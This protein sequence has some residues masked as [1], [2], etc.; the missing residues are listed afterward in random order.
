M[1]LRPG[2]HGRL[3]QIGAVEATLDGGRTLLPETIPAGDPATNRGECGI[4]TIGCLS[5]S[6]QPP[7]SPRL[8]E[9]LMVLLFVVDLKRENNRTL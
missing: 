2:R 7:S 1:A 4:L 8:F 5:K 3:F 9:A 6:P